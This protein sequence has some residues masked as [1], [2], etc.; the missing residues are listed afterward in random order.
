M[1]AISHIRHE[2]EAHARHVFTN[3]VAAKLVY[4]ISFSLRHRLDKVRII[5]RA[6]LK[7]EAIILLAIEVEE[8]FDLPERFLWQWLRKYE[9]IRG[10]VVATEGDHEYTVAVL[11]YTRVSNG[12]QDLGVFVAKPISRLLDL[13]LHPSKRST[14]V[15]IPKMFGRF[16]GGESLASA[17]QTRAESE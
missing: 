6:R 2:R 7:V 12:V 17:P 14:L 16:R 13:T 10:E 15:M 1:S 4:G 11:R 5:P 9:C 3:V 8:L